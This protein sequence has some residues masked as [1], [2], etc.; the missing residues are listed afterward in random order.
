MCLLTDHHIGYWWSSESLGTA[1]ILHSVVWI[2]R[3]C[4]DLSGVKTGSVRC[5]SDFIVNVATQQ[6]RQQRYCSLTALLLRTNL[7]G[8]HVVCFE[9]SYAGLGQGVW[10]QNSTILFCQRDDRTI[11]VGAS[12]RMGRCGS[13]PATATVGLVSAVETTTSYFGSSGL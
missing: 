9:S 2:A 10:C 7:V 1:D 12:R 5:D 11:T 3:I 13:T 8:H 6:R 4:Q